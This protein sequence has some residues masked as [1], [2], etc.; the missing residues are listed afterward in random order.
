MTTPGAA[1]SIAA[2]MFGAS[3]GAGHHNAALVPHRYQPED[4][5]LKGELNEGEIYA[6]AP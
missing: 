1:S 4:S 5:R 6:R 2:L 3:Y